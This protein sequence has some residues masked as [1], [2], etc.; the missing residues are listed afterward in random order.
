M[1][2]SLGSMTS[3]RLVLREISIKVHIVRVLKPSWGINSPHGGFY[4]AKSTLTTSDIY[5]II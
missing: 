4:F 2:L 1:T 5:G 3:H